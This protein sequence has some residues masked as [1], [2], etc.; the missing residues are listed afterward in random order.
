MTLLLLLWRIISI[1][2]LRLCYNKRKLV[3]RVHF[4][5]RV[6][7]ELWG[8]SLFRLMQTYFS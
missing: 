5:W 3:Y 7:N 2:E 1:Y 8:A 4:Y 6:H